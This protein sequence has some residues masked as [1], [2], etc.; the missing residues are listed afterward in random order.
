MSAIDEVLA[1]AQAEIG[2]PYVFAEEGPNAFDCSGLVQWVFGKV[3]IQTP[4]IAAQQ[5]DWATPVST[6]RPGDLVFFGNPAH[7][8]GIYIGAGK[9]IDAPHRGANVRVDSIGTPTSYGRVPGLGSGVVAAGW[10]W[11]TGVA[12]DAVGTVLGGSRHIVI[13][14]MAAA[15]GAGLAIA[16][17]WLLARNRRG[18]THDVEA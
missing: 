13:E 15:A 7:H 8:V 5:Q 17:L 14:G 16:G 12:G 3:G 2:K 6:P 10:G 18:G 9:M 1:A 11:V 4:R